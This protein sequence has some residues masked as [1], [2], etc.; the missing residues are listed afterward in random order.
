MII[1]WTDWLSS[2][3]RNITSYILK[4]SFKIVQSTF[5]HSSSPSCSIAN[6]CDYNSSSTLPWQSDL[7]SKLLIAPILAVAV[8]YALDGLS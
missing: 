1:S 8:P 5:P 2:M 6:F 4:K 7:K 3:T